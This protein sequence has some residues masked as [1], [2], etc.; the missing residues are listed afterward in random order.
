MSTRSSRSPR[1]TQALS[2][3]RIAEAAVELLDGAGE[4]G[5][6][7]R[8]LTERLSTGPGAI[9]WHVSNRVELLGAATEAVVTEALAAG[10]PGSSVTPQDE[11]CAIALGL[12]G[13]VDEHPWLAAQLSAQ[14]SRDPWG[15]VTTH[16][17][18][19]IGGEVQAMDVPR[20]ELFQLT[21]VLVH[22]ILGAAG[23]SA[24]GAGPAQSGVERADFLE[25]AARAWGELDIERFP[26][27]RAVADQVPEHDDRAQLIAGIS[28][29][30]AGIAAR[31]SGAE[32]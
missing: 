14:L 31:R 1:R 12:F 22:Y 17:L 5:L 2:R 9:Y 7:F 24:A 26:F 16:V 4:A 11:I 23:Q 10:P 15:S 32:G 19:R 28:V 25:A 29:I 8:A 21:S 6:T 20:D 30:L 13:A 27:I 18:E 3:A